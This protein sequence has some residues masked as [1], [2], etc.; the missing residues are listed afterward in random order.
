MIF[1]SSLWFHYKTAYSQQ[2]QT[3]F[4]YL[5]IHLKIQFWVLVFV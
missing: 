1:D 4:F 3:M 2:T 5:K